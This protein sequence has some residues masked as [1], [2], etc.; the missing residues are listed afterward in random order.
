MFNFAKNIAGGIHPVDDGKS[1]TRNQPIERLNELPPRLYLQLK[2]HPGAKALAIVREGDAVSAGQLIASA[3]GR[4]SAPVHAPLNGRVV[5][6]DEQ[7]I[8]IKPDRVQIPPPPQPIKETPPH[9]PALMLE[10]IKNAGIVGMGGAMFPLYDKLELCDKYDIDSLLINGSE[11]EPYMTCDDRVMREQSAQIVGGIRLLMQ[12]TKAKQAIIGIEKNKPEAID[13]M[14]SAT[15]EDENIHVHPLPALYPLGS[16]KQ[17]IRALTGIQ[18]AEGRR[19]ASYGV[20]VHNVASCIA[21]FE[22]IRIGRPMTHRVVTIS[23]RAVTQPRNILAPIGTP[24]SHLI[25]QCGGLVQTPTQQIMGGPMMGRMITSV[26]QPIVKGTCGILMLDETES[27]ISVPS[28][29]LRCGRCAQVCPMQLQPLHLLP[30]VQHEQFDEAKTHGLSQCLSCGA[31]AYVCPASLPLTASFNWGK[32]ELKK[33]RYMTTKSETTR[34]RAAD[35]QQRL[36]AEAE[37]KKAAKAAK[38]AKRKSRRNSPAQEE[39]I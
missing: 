20:L 27:N 3:N 29:C 18:L 10:L 6:V 28:S 36:A 33:Q 16:S 7:Q 11:C 13:A 4:F 8:E 24:I 14:T 17:L 15:S 31:C 26:H 37:A 34:Q 2:Q 19:S 30:L 23:G 25:S 1:L 12:I 5:G 21:V 38:A 9:E 35:H 39:T 22:A 32:F